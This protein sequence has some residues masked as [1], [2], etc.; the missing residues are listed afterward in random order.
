[1]HNEMDSE[2]I[3]QKAR[4]MCAKD[5]QEEIKENGILPPSKNKSPLWPP[6]STLEYEAMERDTAKYFLYYGAINMALKNILTSQKTKK[7]IK[8][9]VLGPGRGRLVEYVIDCMKNNN[10]IGVVHVI[11]AND[12][13]LKLIRERYSDVSRVIVHKALVIRDC[14]ETM[15]LIKGAKADDE[16]RKLLQD[17]LIDLIV[18]ELFGSFGDNE[19][20][21]EIL[22]VA[23]RLFCN[24]GCI[25]IPQI[26]VNYITPV[27]SVT[28]DSFFNKI[29]EES[30]ILDNV[31]ITG[32]PID[33]ILLSEAKELYSNE[34]VTNRNSHNPMSCIVALDFREICNFNSDAF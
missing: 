17:K 30:G 2:Y 20:M 19:F 1:M 8:V 16:L 31:Y 21:P 9:L 13:C 25:S 15:K 7:S 24:E 4:E 12:S 18:S 29:E 23:M 22:S 11:D 32:L 26:Y 34:C 28:L 14:D 33:T 6:W 27:Y 3:L 10:I 5:Y